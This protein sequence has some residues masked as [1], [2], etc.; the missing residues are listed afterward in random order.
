MVFGKK[1]F[2]FMGISILLIVVGFALMAGG[3]S[4]DGTS[5]NPEIFSFQR[6]K[7]APL[8]CVAGFS[9]MIYAI[10]AKPKEKDK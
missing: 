1:N 7:L 4:T 10:M 8:L 3:Q 5:F 9:L 6:I 2:I